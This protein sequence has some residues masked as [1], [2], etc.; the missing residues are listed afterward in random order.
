MSENSIKV[1]HMNLKLPLPHNEMLNLIATE[2]LRN[3]QNTLLIL[4]QQEY[5]RR[6]PDG[7]LLAGK[8]DCADLG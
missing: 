6:H 3:K 4:I 5:L 7:G 2:D 8:T 1:S